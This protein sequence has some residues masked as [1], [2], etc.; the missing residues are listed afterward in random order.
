MQ[1]MWSKIANRFLEAKCSNLA[2]SFGAGTGW[3][4]PPPPDPF[5][6]SQPAATAPNPS[7]A[8]LLSKHMAHTRT[9]PG[10]VLP[11]LHQTVCCLKAIFAS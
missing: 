3:A 7:R 2:V 6:H 1:I 9:P 8:R 11:H 10:D 5:T 4:P